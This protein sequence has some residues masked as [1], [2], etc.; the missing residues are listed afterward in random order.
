LRNDTTLAAILDQAN[1]DR[2][3]GDAI[4]SEKIDQANKDRAAGDA[5]LGEKIDQANKD[6]AAGDAALSDKID[7]LA[8][9]M[10][11]IQGSQEGIKWFVAN[12]DIIASGVSVARSLGWI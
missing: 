1:K 5:I 11:N 6:R 3:A 4:L 8:E 10:M 12:S 2:A 9:M 7:N